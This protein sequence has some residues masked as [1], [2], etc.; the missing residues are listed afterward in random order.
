MWRLNLYI[1]KFKYLFSLILFFPLSIIFFIL[2]IL[3]KPILQVRIAKFRSDKI[4]HL[5]LD[6]ELYLEEKIRKINFPKNRYIDLWIKNPIIANQ[7]LYKLRKNQ[8]I[9]VM[10]HIFDGILLLIN[11]FKL[12]DLIIERDNPDA[13]IFY[14][15]DNSNTKLTINNEKNFNQKNKK[16][17]V[18][19]GYQDKLKIV[20]INIRDSAFRGPSNFTNYRNTYNY[21][22]F[23]DTIDYLI[24]NNFFV[25]RVGKAAHYKF[26]LKKNFI[27]YPFSSIQSDEMD[28][29]MSKICYFC[30]STG[31]GMDSL[32]RAFRN[33]VLF[34]NFV[35][36]GYF[37]SYGKKNMTIFKHLIDNDGNKISL[38]KMLNMDILNNLNGNIF[39]EK[40]ISFQENSSHEILSATK[41]ML[42]YIENNFYKKETCDDKL[43][44]DF[45]TSKIKKKYGNTPH[46]EI[47]SLI[48]PIFLKS[49]TY[50]F[51]L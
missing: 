42:A 44:K 18:K 13:D 8:I 3:I 40:K 50:L 17:L 43:V 30:I 31:S 39:L 35:P 32:V 37:N 15:L 51:D 12:K 34:T 24:R 49:N 28:L 27:D 7:F 48:C 1:L 26:P 47:Y 14:I 21:E 11:F 16:I 38:N 19:N 29:Y 45:Y 41:S 5:S 22:N 20:L 6:Y 23:N 36:H 4:G 10:N 9:L 25:I 46:N 2:I 33:P